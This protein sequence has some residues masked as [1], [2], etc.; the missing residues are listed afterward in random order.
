MRD[1][2]QRE[3]STKTHREREAL[4]NKR[5][6]EASQQKDRGIQRKKRH[7][8]TGSEH[9][10]RHQDTEDTHRQSVFQQGDTREREKE[11]ER[12]ASSMGVPGVGVSTKKDIKTQKTHTDRV[13]S[14]KETHTRERMCV[15]VREC[16][17]R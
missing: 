13:C 9:I 10:E 11:R 16:A 15:C 1:K 3:E 17:H 4:R 12:E 5:Q 14:N 2:R 7:S 8:M 6:K